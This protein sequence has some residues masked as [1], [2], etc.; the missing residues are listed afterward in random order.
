MRINRGVFFAVVTSLLVSAVQMNEEILTDRSNH[1]LDQ[2]GLTT[3]YGDSIQVPVQSQN[4]GDVA[5]GVVVFDNGTRLHLDGNPC[6]KLIYYFRAPYS[7]SRTGRKIP[8]AG[9]EFEE[10]RVKQK[11]V[12]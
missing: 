6:K 2:A 1:A 11:Q 5:L 10:Y 12:K 3:V 9:V 7:Q 4:A 8:C